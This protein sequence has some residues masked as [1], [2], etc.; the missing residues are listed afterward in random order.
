MLPPIAR[1]TEV[2]VDDAGHMIP[3]R[4]VAKVH[5]L[6]LTMPIGT[7]S[8]NQKVWRQLDEDSLDS[9]TSVLLAQNGLRAGVGPQ[10]R[11]PAIAKLI[12]LPGATTQEY[13]C[14]TDG[15]TSINIVTRA[16]IPEQTVFYVDKD[17]QLQGRT[18]D[19]CDN[20]VRLSM[21]KVKDSSDLVVQVEPV[22]QLGTIEVLRGRRKW[23]WSA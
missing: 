5:L 13:F 18:F 19:R 1:P 4:P 14:Q 2:P 3:L 6:K 16:N 7:F 23:A 11:W 15:R 21:N 12:D 8:L 20:A 22:V 17:L 10:S 9:K